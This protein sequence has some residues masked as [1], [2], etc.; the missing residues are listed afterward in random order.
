MYTAIKNIHSFWAYAAIGLILIAAINALWGMSSRKSFTA[1]DRKISLFGLIAAHIQFLFGIVLYFVSPIVKSAME[2]G[3]GVA[4]KNSVLRLYLVE[5]PII[6]LV[7]IVLITIG[8]SRHKKTSVDK[9]KF[10]RIGWMYL[11]G[12]LLLLSRIPWSA[13]LG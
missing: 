2:A 9:S 10:S 1:R 6:N 4:M 7:A 5:H 13:W 8:W 12:L 3:M 11:I